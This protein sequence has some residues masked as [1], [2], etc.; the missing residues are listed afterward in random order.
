M[1]FGIKNKDLLNSKGKGCGYCDRAK[2]AWR[3]I[4]FT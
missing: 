4:I 1:D 2:T 3:R